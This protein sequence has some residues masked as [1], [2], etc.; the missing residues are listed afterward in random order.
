MHHCKEKYFN[1]QK[2]QYRNQ[3]ILSKITC[4]E[5]P[6]GARLDLEKSEKKLP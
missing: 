5:Y 6:A 3:Q 2:H 4:L 1:Q